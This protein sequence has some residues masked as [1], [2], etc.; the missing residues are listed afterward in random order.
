MKARISLS[1]QN[2]LRPSLTF[3]GADPTRDQLRHVV[4][5]TGTMR[6]TSSNFISLSICNPP[7]HNSS[8]YNCGGYRSLSICPASFA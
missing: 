2:V 4:L 5:D 6:S 1:R 8:E 7:H 3:C